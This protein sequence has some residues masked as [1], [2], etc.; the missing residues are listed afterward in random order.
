MKVRATVELT[1]K[2]ASFAEAGDVLDAILADARARPGV[3]VDAAELGTPDERARVTLPP[4]PAPPA[5]ERRDTPWMAGRQP[6]SSAPRASGSR[7][8]AT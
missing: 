4:P 2:A 7:A 8:G 6:V 5:P 1:V 3:T